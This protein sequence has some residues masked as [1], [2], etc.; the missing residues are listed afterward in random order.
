MSQRIVVV[1]AGVIGAAIAN[2]LAQ[3]GHQVT[4]VD[5]VGPAGDASGRSFG[6]INASFFADDAHFR[7]R[8]AGIEAWRRTDVRGLTWSG[9]LWYE[10]DGD[11]LEAMHAQLKR[12]NYPVELVDTEHFK[13]LEPHVETP[14]KRALRLPSEAAA[15]TGLVTQSLLA[16]AQAHGATALFGVDVLAID[17]RNGVVNSIETSAGMLPA[18]CVVVA[19]GTGSPALVEPH[20][21]ALPMLRRP[22]LLVTTRPVP[23]V[24]SHILVAP[25][26]ELRQLPDGRFLAPTSPNHQADEAKDLAGSAQSLA[27][28]ALE[29]LSQLIPRHPA[30]IES[31]SLAFRPVPQD[32]L[33][34]VGPAG[35]DGLYIAT[36]H[37]GVTLAAIIGELVAQ[38]LTNGGS[39]ELLAPYRPTRFAG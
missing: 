26:Q 4:V 24:L 31:T 1:G 39:A 25:G 34:V 23:P 17:T 37:S 22:G 8:S 30:S 27:D 33:P 35:P 2:Q 29:R 11:G 21:V 28:A 19:A 12:F 38:E 6:W 16:R 3:A 18:D 15:D 32:G 20:G 7:L 13:S 36:M 5:R 10:E 14:P 9:S